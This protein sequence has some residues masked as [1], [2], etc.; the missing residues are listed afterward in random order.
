MQKTEKTLRFM[1]ETP[2][3]PSFGYNIVIW[4]KFIWKS[5]KYISS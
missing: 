4:L 2:R 1:Y 5:I 3:W